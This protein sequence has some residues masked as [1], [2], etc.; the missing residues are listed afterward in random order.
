MPQAPSP[1]RFP[2]LVRLP[3][4]GRVYPTSATGS[5]PQ[6]VSCAGEIT[7]VTRNYGART[8]INLHWTTS[9]SDYHRG[10]SWFI[11]RWLPCRPKASGGFQKVLPVLL[12][13]YPMDPCGVWG[14]NFSRDQVILLAPPIAI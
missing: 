2:A 11:K 7:P 13:P 3:L 8:R 6:K 12:V 5:P 4:I 14:E 9:L 10:S 1:K